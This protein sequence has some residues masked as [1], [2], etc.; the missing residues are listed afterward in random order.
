MSRRTRR[1]V[2][3]S[4]SLLAAALALGGCGSEQPGAEPGTGASAGDGAA[5]SPATGGN[6]AADEAG[7][8]AG[9]PC[10]L[11][12]AAQAK[13]A[14]KVKKVGPGEVQDGMCIYAAVPAV[15]IKNI[16][17]GP[18]AQAKNEAELQ[19]LLDQGDSAGLKA[20]ELSGIGDAAYLVA[21]A[22]IVHVV[23]DGTPYVV[24]GLADKASLTRAAKSLAS[25]LS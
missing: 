18:N 12:T 25:N 23:V 14:L 15:P 5:A 10:E 13:K 2:L 22:N 3:L 1:L 9:D 6:E 7:A 8:A 20:E 17:A 16:G 11:L 24:S 19:T 21:D 4:S